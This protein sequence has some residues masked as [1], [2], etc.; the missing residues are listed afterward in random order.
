M[1]EKSTACI[2]LCWPGVCNQV[3]GSVR[4]LVMQ[5]GCSFSRA[6]ILR[7]ERIILDKLDWDLYTATAVDFVHIVSRETTHTPH[8]TDWLKPR[9]EKAKPTSSNQSGDTE[10][11]RVRELGEHNSLYYSS[12]AFN[13]RTD[14]A[15]KWLDYV[16]NIDLL[17]SRNVRV[18]AEKH[19]DWMWKYAKTDHFHK[20]VL[21]NSKLK[22]HQLSVFFFPT[23]FKRQIKNWWEG[24]TARVFEP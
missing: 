12:V 20:N 16:L 18:K 4:D 24:V 8:Q 9:D 19:Q 1:W 22:L 13:L 14:C 11:L 2:L 15:I 6:E 3:L 23:N 21:L 17:S 7:M 10:S 5:S